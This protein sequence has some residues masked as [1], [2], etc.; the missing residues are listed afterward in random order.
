MGFLGAM[1][2]PMAYGD[3]F[4]PTSA[5]APWYV[6]VNAI[7]KQSNDEWSG[8]GSFRGLEIEFEFQTDKL[9][10]YAIRSTAW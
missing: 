4:V 3:F 9:I 10:I 7:Y 6:N 1:T 8:C 2:N 5:F